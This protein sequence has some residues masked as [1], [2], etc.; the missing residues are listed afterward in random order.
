MNTTVKLPTVAFMDDEGRTL[1]LSSRLSMPT[2]AAR[3]SREL[4]LRDDHDA[5][6]TAKDVQIAQLLHLSAAF[7]SHPEGY[8]GPCMCK[9]CMSY[10]EEDS[11]E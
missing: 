8:D 1:E 3:Y 10:A 11:H 2:I 4:V 6:M 9:V 5:Q 7:N